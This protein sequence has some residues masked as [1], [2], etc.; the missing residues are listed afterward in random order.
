MKATCDHGGSSLVERVSGVV[1]GVI[2]SGD[3]GAIY[4]VVAKTTK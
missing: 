2:I 3:S 4:S 1:V